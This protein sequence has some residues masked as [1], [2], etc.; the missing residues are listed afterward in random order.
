MKFSTFLI[1]AMIGVIALIFI[2]TNPGHSLPG[3]SSQEREA[4]QAPEA[5]SASSARDANPPATEASRR[6][7]ISGR[8][9]RRLNDGHILVTGRVTEIGKTEGIAGD[10]AVSGRS[11]ASLI[12][13][14]EPIR[15]EVQPA[16]NYEFAGDG[17]STRTIPKFIAVRPPPGA[18]RAGEWMREGNPLE[19]GA[20]ISR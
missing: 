1:L 4:A 11:D 8:V 10:F 16:G 18:A 6:F 2:G 17:G 5:S 15:C 14:G 13:N 20:Y 9:T 19:R 3:A 12:A 7:E